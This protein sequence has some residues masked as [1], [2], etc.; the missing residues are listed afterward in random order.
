MM[1]DI[2]CPADLGAAID[3]EERKLF[4][5][6]RERDALMILIEAS[7]HHGLKLSK[8]EYIALKIKHG[9]V[10]AEANRARALVRAYLP[11]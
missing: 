7:R 9:N 2:E 6:R 3:D 1:Y 10:E 8:D 4:A 5:A 11:Q